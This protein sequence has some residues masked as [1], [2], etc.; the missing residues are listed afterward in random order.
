VRPLDHRPVMSRETE[1]LLSPPSV[2]TVVG[3]DPYTPSYRERY[4][5]MALPGNLVRSTKVLSPGPERGTGG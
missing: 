1:R 4:G 2:G 5:P 3:D